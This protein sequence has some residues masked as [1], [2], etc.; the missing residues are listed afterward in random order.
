[1]LVVTGPANSGKTTTLY[2]SLL[3][4]NRLCRGER[5]IATVEDPVEFPVDG[6][7]QSQ[8]NPKDRFG[9]AEALRAMMRQDPQVIM[10]G[11]IRDSETAAMAVHASL[12][13]HLILTT[14]HAKE[15]TG[16]FPRLQ[17]LGIE[18]VRLAGA[19]LA[20]LNQRLI[21]LNCAQCAAPYSPGRQY[22]RYLPV[23]VTEQ[24]KF[25]RG[26][27]CGACGNTG[28]SGR[29]TAAELLIMTS[30]L[31]GAVCARVPAQEIYNRAITSGMTTIWQ[32]A[33]RKVCAGQIALEET[34]LA[35]GTESE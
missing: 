15:V 35:L 23:Q 5:N 3:E 12:T 11:E 14:V 2:S 21:R 28:H 33:L 6:L 34:V 18:P 26:T 32:D 4:I 27:G 10:V 9:F 31:R 16:V 25:R 29:T 24:A 20:V 30:D 1:M 19:V 22:L 17:A 7:S 13:G 8:V